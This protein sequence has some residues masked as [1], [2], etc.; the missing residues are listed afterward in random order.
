MSRTNSLVFSGAL[1]SAMFSVVIGCTGDDNDNEEGTA[2]TTSGAAAG[3]GGSD[4]AGA[5]GTNGG[6]AGTSVGGAGAGGAG[7]SSSVDFTSCQPRECDPNAQLDYD[8]SGGWTERIEFT[9]NDCDASLQEILP[10][11]FYQE[12]STITDLLVGNCL[13][14]EPTSP[15]YGGS[16]ALDLSGAEYCTQSSFHVESQ[17]ID[18]PLV[19][20]VVWESIEPGKLT[21][22]TAVYVPLAGCTLHGDYELSKP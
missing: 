11:S 16:I 8:F 6:S 5:A 4:S 15:I 19:S 20:H 22:K 7:G 18:V 9:S 21:G 2:G 12:G 14:P 17:G 3:S 1:L 10:P 13:K